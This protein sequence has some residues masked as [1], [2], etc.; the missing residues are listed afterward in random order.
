MTEKFKRNLTR[1]DWQP[2]DRCQD[3][4]EHQ[5]VQAGQQAPQKAHGCMVEKGCTG[6]GLE[7]CTPPK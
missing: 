7:M 4:K 6:I 1:S 2:R 5:Q 3:M